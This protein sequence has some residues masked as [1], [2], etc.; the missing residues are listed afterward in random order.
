MSSHDPFC[1]LLT[2]KACR[3]RWEHTPEWSYTSKLLISKHQQVQLL[4][5]AS[6][7]VTMNQDPDTPP[8]SAKDLGSDH[9]SASPAASGSSGLR[10]DM[11]STDTTPP[12]QTEEQALASASARGSRHGR[13]KRYSSNASS[14]SRSYQS[15]PSNSLPAGSFPLES[16]GFGHARH[17]SAEQRPASA[18]VALAGQRDEDEAGLAAAVGLLSCSFGTPTSRPV[19]L[20]AD[21][22]PVPPLPARFMGTNGNNLSGSTATPSSHQAPK[23][24]SSEY[25]HQYIS[26]DR[27][28]KMDDSEESAAEDEYDD[29]RSTSR[30]RSDEDDD[31]V[32]GRMEE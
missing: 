28:T 2:D 25:G 10:G 29:Q 30:G 14:Y 19:T 16:C 17:L 13:S 24:P 11:S 8:D 15:A 9:S 31:G 1:Y 27:D 18:G 21:V 26:R 5:A 4:E 12:P 3:D 20:P 6:V 23:D 32:F 22:P 7:L